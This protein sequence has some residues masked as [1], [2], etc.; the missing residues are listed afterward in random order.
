MS[1]GYDTTAEPG[2]VP[3]NSCISLQILQSAAGVVLKSSNL[4]Q[5]D[6]ES[7]QTAPARSIGESQE[8]RDLISQTRQKPQ[9]V[10]HQLFTSPASLDLSG[11]VELVGGVSIVSVGIPFDG[12]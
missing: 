11:I 10:L 2:S 4:L 5:D 3:G 1:T 9:S 12:P 8:I 7:P 6:A